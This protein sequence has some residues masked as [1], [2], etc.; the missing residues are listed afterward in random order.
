MKKDIYY[1]LNDVHCYVY[2]V[3]N[4]CIKY[5]MKKVLFFFFLFVKSV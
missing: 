2:L 5:L 3:T 4:N 1:K